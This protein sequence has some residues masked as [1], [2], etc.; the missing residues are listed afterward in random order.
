MCVM[1]GVHVNEVSSI[2]AA[3]RLTD[4]EDWGYTPSDFRRLLELSPGGCFAAE[5]AGEVVGV[6]TTTTYDEL[7]FLGAVIVRPELRGRGVGKQM[8]E[9]ALDHL[10]ALQEH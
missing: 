3:I 2:D 10:R 8:M 9:A 6:L 7:A 4:L 5:L 1:A